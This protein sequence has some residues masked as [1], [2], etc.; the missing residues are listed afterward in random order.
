MDD[1]DKG[2][3]TDVWPGFLHLTCGAFTLPVDESLGS[4]LS[5]IPESTAVKQLQ[6]AFCRAASSFASSFQQPLTP[7]VTSVSEQYNPARYRKERGAFYVMNVTFDQPEF[8]GAI[9]QMMRQ[10]CKD[11]GLPVSKLLSKGVSHITIRKYG[12]QH[13]MRGYSSRPAVAIAML[14]PVLAAKPLKLTCD[15][16]QLV[17]PSNG[18]KGFKFSTHG[19]IAALSN[20]SL[21]TVSGAEAAADQSAENASDHDKLCYRR[22][23]PLWWQTTCRFHQLDAALLANLQ[24]LG[25][26]S[27]LAAAALT[28]AQDGMR[29]SRSSADSTHTITEE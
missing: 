9:Q 16:L 4:T 3:L 15:I 18:S 13:S 21:G 28:A 24:L 27:S 1:L 12:D 19:V 6:Q 8:A 10:V 2:L 25:Q 5:I 14:N 29:A 17:M 26:S 23:Q 7:T 22:A 20:G 11:T